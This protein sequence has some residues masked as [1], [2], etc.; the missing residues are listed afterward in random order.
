MGAGHLSDRPE[1]REYARVERE[2][3]FLVDH[4]PAAAVAYQRLVDLYIDGTQM[5]LRRIE[6]PKGE[7][8]ICKLGQKLIDPAAPNDPRR[9]QMTTLYL[10]PG[11]DRLLGELPGHRS[12]KRRYKLPEQGWTFCVDVYEQPTGAAG[13]MVCEV[14]CDTCRQL[15]EIRIPTWA[16]R[17]ITADPQYWGAHLAR[18]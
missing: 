16:T 7:L 8:I 15:D 14:E 6:S 18:R 9:R 2:R 4:L 13:I 11:E 1:R 17:E 3:R 12:V 10:Q 5:R